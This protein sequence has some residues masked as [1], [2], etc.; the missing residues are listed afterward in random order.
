MTMVVYGS[1]L[2]EVS[3][4]RGMTLHWTFSTTDESLRH[5]TFHVFAKKRSLFMN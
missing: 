4:T 5:N 1:Q 3:Q 2:T